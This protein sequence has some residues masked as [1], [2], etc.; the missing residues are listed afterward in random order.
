MVRRM[1]RT[2]DLSDQVTSVSITSAG[3]TNA[4]SAEMNLTKFSWRKWLS[5]AAAKTDHVTVFWLVVHAI[6]RTTK[7]SD[8]DA[9]PVLTNQRCPVR[10]S[11]V[12]GHQL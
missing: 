12:L 11:A 6:R 8:R 10:W 1:T 5:T 9:E 2:S 4:W 7:L 3:R